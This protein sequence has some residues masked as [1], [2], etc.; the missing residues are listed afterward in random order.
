MPKEG[1]DL[2]KREEQRWGAGEA[3]WSGSIKRIRGSVQQGQ[4]KRADKGD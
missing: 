2:M 3:S 4:E 1:D